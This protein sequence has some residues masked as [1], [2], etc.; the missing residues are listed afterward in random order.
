M[1]SVLANIHK[2]AFSECR[3]ILDILLNKLILIL[4]LILIL[5]YT[6]NYN[7]IIIIISLGLNHIESDYHLI[8]HLN[9]ILNIKKQNI[10]LFVIASFV[11]ILPEFKYSTSTS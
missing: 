6:Y 9:S 5:S 2:L 7:I 8:Q 1:L 3:K 10:L 11:L 4:I